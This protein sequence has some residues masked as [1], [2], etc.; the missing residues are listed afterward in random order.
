MRGESLRRAVD[1]YES[2][3]FGDLAFEEG[4]VAQCR[5]PSQECASKGTSSTKP[6]NGSNSIGS[7]GLSA[8]RVVATRAIGVALIPGQIQSP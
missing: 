8:C 1:R 2:A 3:A 7:V 6:L 5:N 4:V